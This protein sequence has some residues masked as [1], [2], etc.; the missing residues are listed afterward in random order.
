MITVSGIFT[1]KSL[2]LAVHTFQDAFVLLRS[3]TNYERQGT[4]RYDKTT[5]DLGRMKRLLKAVGSPDRDLA[6]YHVAGTKGKGTVS[7]ILGCCLQAA[8]HR[9]GVYTSPHLRHVRERARVQGRPIPKRAFA[10]LV[11]EMRPRLLD[12]RDRPT[13]F[14]IITALALRHFRDEG[15]D[16][17]VLEV[18][19]GGRFD[20]TNVVRPR[21]GL[22][23][24]ISLEHQRYLGN[25]LRAI[26]GEKA[27]IAKA[28]VP[29]VSGVRDASSPGRAI[30]KRA[31]A[32]GAPLRVIGR[33]FLVDRVEQ[34][35]GDGCGIRFD[36][37]G[38][39]GVWRGME[40][41]ILGRHHAT[42][43]AVAL[44]ALATAGDDDPA[45]RVTEAQARRGLR[46]VRA[47]GRLQVVGRR[48]WTIVDGAHNP[49]SIRATIRTIREDVPHDRL[50]I[51]FG[52]MWDKDVKGLLDEILPATDWLLPVRVDL[53]RAIPAD[54]IT[55]MAR[56]HPS[57]PRI[58]L[59][60]SPE[61]AVAHARKHIGANG[62]VLVTGSLV[63]AGHV[64][65]SL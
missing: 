59:A 3:L 42:N 45:L 6:V 44:E 15:A 27:G 56:R 36:W 63:L 49:A 25:T 32:V 14:E 28:G 34:A 46:R 10:R 4:M 22:I 20:A 47:E 26:A 38:R 31:E 1:R 2:A 24:S 35:A 23:T 57:R 18:G 30:R 29:L 50:A 19:L 16:V 52:S 17:A 65:E 5:L 8:G 51:V 21:V 40:M 39:T 43:A 13:F 48:P 62:A 12:V 61:E 60:G 41:P 53:A 7:E 11:E 9:V 54:E 58:H 37:T 64:L 33:E 55:A